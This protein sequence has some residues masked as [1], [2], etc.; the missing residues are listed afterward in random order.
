MEDEEQRELS[1]GEFE[2][3]LEVAK[4]IQPSMALNMQLVEL[5]KNTWYRR[6]DQ[7]IDRYWASQQDLLCLLKVGFEERPFTLNYVKK[8]HRETTTSALKEKV[9]PDLVK[10]GMM[11]KDETGRYVTYLVTQ[12]GREWLLYNIL[13]C[14]K[15]KMTGGCP[16]CNKGIDL[17]DPE[18]KDRCYSCD[19]H[20]RCDRCI[21]LFEEIGGHPG[22]L[23]LIERS[24]IVN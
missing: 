2:E 15:C 8:K 9:I 20:G 1:K 22:L 11:I 6:E 13:H 4:A 23:E 16:H 3:C 5:A 12:V 18:G 21:E 19:G 10:V 24:V 7:W 17:D 14:Q